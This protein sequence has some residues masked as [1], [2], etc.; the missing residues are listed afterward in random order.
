MVVRHHTLLAER[1]LLWRH[2]RPFPRRR[3]REAEL[4]GAEGALVVPTEQIHELVDDLTRCAQTFDRARWK[5][6]RVLLQRFPLAHEFVLLRVQSRRF[7]HTRDTDVAAVGHALGNRGASLPPAEA[8]APYLDALE[9]L[10]I[11]RALLHN[12]ADVHVGQ[13]LA[14]ESR[15]SLLAHDHGIAER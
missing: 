13:A 5:V 4:D 11:G 2:D 10:G 9:E 1:Q 14:E 7:E 3:L 15:A 6:A 12:L 8:P